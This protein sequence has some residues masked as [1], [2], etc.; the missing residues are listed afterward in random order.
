MERDYRQLTWGSPSNFTPN[1]R[2]SSDHSQQDEL[3][4]E[5]PRVASTLGYTTEGYQSVSSMDNRQAGDGSE[6]AMWTTPW[7]NGM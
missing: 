7:E 6:A 3:F 5:Q 4:T 2:I 1:L